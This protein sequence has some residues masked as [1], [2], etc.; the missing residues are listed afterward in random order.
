MQPETNPAR[1]KVLKRI[2]FLKQDQ[3]IFKTEE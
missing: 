2:C 3:L 1:L